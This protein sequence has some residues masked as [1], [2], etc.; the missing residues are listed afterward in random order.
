MRPTP[1]LGMASEA[2]ASRALPGPE[3]KAVI[4]SEAKDC[5]VF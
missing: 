5:I 4:V 2:F 3:P 1:L